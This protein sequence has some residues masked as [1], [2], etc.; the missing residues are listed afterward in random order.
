MNNNIN[1]S[2]RLKTIGD[3]VNSN[4]K[5][6]DVGCDH[7]L[8]SIY[9][10]LN[11]TKNII[12]S[13]INSNPLKE[14]HKNLCKYNLNDKLELKISNGL[15]CFE[16][17][18]FDTI[19]IAGMGGMTIIDILNS[20]IKKLYNTKKIII[21]SN[22]DIPKIRKFIVKLGYIIDNEKLIKE[23]NIIYTIIVFKKSNKK[24]KYGQIDYIIGPILKN[25]KDKIFIDFINSEIIKKE[26]ILKKLPQKYDREIKNLKKEIGL[27]QNLMISNF[28]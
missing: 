4:D 11:K 19:V 26:N 1:I 28:I 3:F 13:D 6:I 27:L 8:L 22:K 15:E 2:N 21:Q 24:V 18:E 7:A 12:A 9:I 17:N 25:S 14:A 5:V 16:G 10:Y 20:G 23:N